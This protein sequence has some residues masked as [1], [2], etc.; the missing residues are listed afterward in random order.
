MKEGW[1]RKKMKDVVSFQ[2]GK[3]IP[4]N[5]EK[6]TGDI[7]YIKV[8]DMNL[9]GN[10][11]NITT[12][13]RYV[14]FSDIKK[15]Q[16][17]PIGSVIFP[18]RGGAIATNKKRKIVKSTIV[19]LN[20]M[21]LIPSKALSDE[22]FYYWFKTIDL[23]KLS[24]GTSVPQINNGSFNDVFLSFPK[25]LQEQEQIVQILDRAFEKIDRAIANI[26]Q[27]IK[28]A[29][30]L[31]QSKLNEVFSQRGDGWE[32]KTIEAISKVINGFSFKSN[33]FSVDNQV[34]AI[35]I[36]NVGIQ[37]FVEDFSNNLPGS[38]LEKY[39]KVK[40][41]EGNLVIALTRTIITGGLKVA[42]VPT[43]YNNSLLN[44]RVAAIVPNSKV[45]D[46]DY[47]YY[48]FSSHRV[49]NYVL[50]KVNTLMQPNLS[51]GD[52]KKM[53]IPLIDLEQQQKISNQIGIL[54]EE[55]NSLITNY[56]IK[57][58]NLRDLKKSFLEKAFKGELARINFKV[59]Y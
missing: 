7:L 25:S 8:G 51:I 29:E 44:Q 14:N 55:T 39:N 18:K 58:K 5:L 21:A 47:L 26:E 16:I 9:L 6:K 53:P 4:K 43:S 11:I 1:E 10:E 20:T 40:V 50:S 28:Y 59:N 3:T 13:S 37:E 49:Y 57:L 52:L 22:Y 45:V 23:N 17:I 2:S 38:F 24:N 48:Y 46:S 35:K 54:S 56:K 15:S 31:F 30:E 42:R 27:N 41:Y 32:E 19:D 12:S 33:D 34:K 36:T